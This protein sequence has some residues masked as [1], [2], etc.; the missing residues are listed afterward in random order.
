MEQTETK[1]NPD[2]LECLANL[3]NDEVFTPPHVANAMLDLLPQELFRDP[4]TTFLDPCCKSG[5]FLREI[6]KRLI[7]GLEPIF[8][9]LQERLDHI[10]HN[11]LFGFAI[12][13]LT[14]LT[15]RRT[16]YCTKLA[17]GEYAISHFD[18]P[19]GNILL[20]PAEHEWV[21]GKCRLCGASKEILKDRAESHAYAFIHGINPEK[22]FHMKF[23]VIIGNPPYQ[24]QDG[25][26]GLGSSAKPLYQNFVETAQRLKPGHLVF[27]IPARWYSGGKGLDEFR[28]NMLEESHLRVLVDYFDSTEC[29]PGVDIS[30][31]VCF[32]T[33]I[34]HIM[35]IA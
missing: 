35:G 32:L 9:D 8:P 18:T 30:G 6:A 4:K 1:H 19:E 3:S 24:L 13:E 21:D 10:F 16:V 23:D 34:K 7:V 14:A 12:T 2:V 20:P 29:F 25:G 22:V 5:I 27:V 28:K 17:N 33:G 31:G 15:S 11:Q 26:G